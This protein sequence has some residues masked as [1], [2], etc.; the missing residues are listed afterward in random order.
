MATENCTFYA[1]VAL[2]D[3]RITFKCDGETQADHAEAVANALVS[4][5]HAVRAEARAAVLASG[6]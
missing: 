4:L 6:S 2:V 1:G 3:G 5:A